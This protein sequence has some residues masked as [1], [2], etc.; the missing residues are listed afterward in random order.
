MFIN[1]SQELSPSEV[2]EVVDMDL[3]EDEEA[4]IRRAVDACV[5][6]L[7]VPEPS[8]EKIQEALEVVGAYKPKITKADDE[9]KKKNKGEGS[10]AVK[11]PRY[12]GLLAEVDLD[13]VLAPALV[14]VDFY[15]KLKE[16]DRVAQR[17]HVTVVHKNSLPDG[18]ELWDRCLRLHQASDPPAFRFR[19]GSLLWN[20]R[21][22]AA[23]VEDIEVDGGGDGPEGEEFVQKL[24]EELRRRLHITVGTR[25]ANV[26]AVEAKDLVEKWRNNG[27]VEGVTE[28]KLDAIMVKGRVKGLFS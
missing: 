3:E 14:D 25:D 19:L 18:Q 7:G 17:P 16:K 11:Q 4:S 27:S 22:M 26:P 10:G 20:D 23:T 13:E 5:R 24:G 12:F 6:I 15:A 2:D 8:E 9:K 1:Q 21:V 28:K